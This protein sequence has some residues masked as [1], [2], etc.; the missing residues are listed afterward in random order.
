MSSLKTIKKL[1]AI[2]AAYSEL[3]NVLD[4]EIDERSKK[5]KCALDKPIDYNAQVE[6]YCKLRTEVRNTLRYNLRQYNVPYKMVWYKH[7]KA[8][9]I[10]E[11]HILIL[12]DKIAKSSDYRK[13]GTCKIINKAQTTKTIIGIL[14]ELRR[15]YEEEEIKTKG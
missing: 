9:Y 15:L 4:M 5:L 7:R 2:R 3:I 14:K 11:E 8:A 10:T 13:D 12:L 1:N 6:A